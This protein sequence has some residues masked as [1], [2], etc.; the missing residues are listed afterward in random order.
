[1][2]IKTHSSKSPWPSSWEENEGNNPK[3][4]HRR[5]SW[6]S[7][8]G[9]RSSP[10]IHGEGDVLANACP[11]LLLAD[12]DATSLVHPAEKKMLL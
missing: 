3:E 1:M 6:E 9:T 12:R 7:P 2:K 8:I 10:G 11:R 5:L 4:H